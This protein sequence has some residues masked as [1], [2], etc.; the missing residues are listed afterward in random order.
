MSIWPTQ[1]QIGDGSCEALSVTFK[2]ENDTTLLQWC[3]ANGGVTEQIYPDP[4]GTTGLL[5]GNTISIT[6][7]STV[8]GLEGW[9][10]Q[11]LLHPVIT[12]IGP[13]GALV[14]EIHAGTVKRITLT[15]YNFIKDRTLCVFL[16]KD[17]NNN[18]PDR[19]QSD[20][21][22][23]IAFDAEAGTILCQIPTTDLAN[24]ANQ[25]SQV[26]AVNIYTPQPGEGAL[27][28]S[29]TFFADTG[30]FAQS[31]NSVDFRY[32]GCPKG[33]YTQDPLQS[34]TDC[35]RGKY[36]PVES[37]V[38]CTVCEQGKYQDSR[39]S[40]VC[41]NCPLGRFRS[42][43]EGSPA[44]ESIPTLDGP[45]ICDACQTGTYQSAG[46]K[47]IC[48]TCWDPA[49]A[50]L[51][52][53]YV[54]F[55]QTTKAT[56]Q[57]QC[58][59]SRNYFNSNR[60]S[61]LRPKCSECNLE[62][63][64]C[65]G[66]NGQPLPQQGWFAPEGS[67]NPNDFKQCS[68]GVSA[69]PGGKGQPSVEATVALDVTLDE[70]VTVQFQTTFRAEVSAELG[71][72]ETRVRILDV[73]PA[74]TEQLTQLQQQRRKKR[75]LHLADWRWLQTATSPAASMTA[76]NSTTNDIPVA[77]SVVIR[78][79]VVAT[80]EGQPQQLQNR[81]QS[82]QVLQ[83]IAIGM[84][85]SSSAMSFLNSTAAVPQRC[86]EGYTGFGCGKCADRWYKLHRK[87]EKC[88]DNS[89]WT[90]AVAVVS[91]VAFLG[92][93]AYFSSGRE[94]LSSVGVA[95][96][97]FFDAISIS[98][99]FLQIN[100]LFATFNIEWPSYLVDLF[101]W[102][103]FLSLNIELAR[104]E[105]SIR[106]DYFGRWSVI[107]LFLPFAAGT[108][109]FFAVVGKIWF[110][111]KERVLDKQI[112][113]ELALR[114]AAADTNTT[115]KKLM[116]DIVKDSKF[117]DSF[118]TLSTL[119]LDDTIDKT[120]TESHEVSSKMKQMYQRMEGEHLFSSKQ[121]LEQMALQKELAKLNSE[122]SE[123]RTNS[124]ADDDTLADA[125][126]LESSRSSSSSSL[127]IDENSSEANTGSSATS[128]D[129][130]R[131]PQTRRRSVS[132]EN[133]PGDA[134]VE[135]PTPDAVPVTPSPSKKKS[136]F[137]RA[138][139]KFSKKSISDD[140]SSN[141]AAN[142]GSQPSLRGRLAATKDGYEHIAFW[143]KGFS[144]YRFRLSLQNAMIMFASIAYVT[145]C[146]KVL[147]VFD[148]TG[149]EEGNALL[150]LDADPSVRCE[151][152]DPQYQ[153]LFPLAVLGLFVYVF[154]IPAGCGYL[155]Y[156]NR[157]VLGD[158][159]CFY[160]F[161]FLIDKY[162]R[163]YFYWELFVMFRKLGL[164]CATLYFTRRPFFQTAIGMV[165]IFIC[166]CSNLVARPYVDKSHD[167]LDIILLF[168]NFLVLVFGLAFLADGFPN[169]NVEEAAGYV[170]VGVIGVGMLAILIA[171][172]S[173]GRKALRRKRMTVAEVD[174]LEDLV[175]SFVLI[176]K[177]GGM[178][179][180]NFLYEV[181][182]EDDIPYV[183]HAMMQDLRE[184]TETDFLGALLR[185][186]ELYRMKE[187]DYITRAKYLRIY[188]KIAAK[189]QMLE[190][191]EAAMKAA[192]EENEPETNEEED[193]ADT[194][195]ALKSPVALARPGSKRFSVDTA[196]GVNSPEV[197][198]LQ[199]QLKQTEEELLEVQNIAH[200]ALE[201]SQDSE[202]PDIGT[203]MELDLGQTSYTASPVSV[204]TVDLVER[205]R[206]PS[207]TDTNQNQKGWFNWFKRSAKS[208]EKHTQNEPS[209]SDTTVDK[210]DAVSLT[211]TVRSHT[212]DSRSESQ[213][214]PS[215]N[216][217]TNSSD[218]D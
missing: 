142:F 104:P 76:G 69:C 180:H 57:Y 189:R 30:F 161:G 34:C 141:N 58:K 111:Y 196:G 203:G 191:K 1:M 153:Y 96:S 210:S 123:N 213:N 125:D 128:T 2:N 43:P 21:R 159:S 39:G 169:A 137:E 33:Q 124:I 24:T 108:F 12:N 9:S 32:R 29:G 199:K 18:I 110:A 50:S 195:D 177:H 77:S 14:S 154:G 70:A 53:A 184:T 174:D 41:V 117:A 75:R 44:Y 103:S 8:V 151:S 162:E 181:F 109:S 46:G 121:S 185:F 97:R 176:L 10:F 164:I 133:I 98:L 212:E 15:G 28:P 116:K 22:N 72:A 175:E 102:I 26:T 114:K 192:E 198:E 126:S 194:G 49:D 42:R 16:L 172:V 140:G 186:A 71:V 204:R 149:F 101:G 56:S 217:A 208:D 64:I 73:N 4:A 83:N 55:P 13:S 202:I 27:N 211:S 129:T 3:G 20:V 89:G 132:F 134:L 209:G 218:S 120:N 205:R 38:P 100:A 106:T 160:R 158:E 130:E 85:I 131:H 170:T 173:V 48:D 31:V 138:K 201:D 113:D 88:P 200:R 92:L 61:T 190:D 37:N 99:T 197:A 157:N 127:K 11:Y 115:D 152:D 19:T 79:E 193:D 107:M 74:T 23:P 59:C 80:D 122:K 62:A 91:L 84:N 187:L 168:I 146:T 147:E 36:S 35:P 183:L 81:L 155:L 93:L 156:R 136:V 51:R 165:V 112:N 7:V 63:A 206:R 215:N 207:K 105:C 90:I 216:N 139:T 143:K 94:A 54:T 6:Y 135:T 78:F 148:C 163:K 65:P 179:L 166:L 118:H 167:W 47:T 5:S 144:Y 171:A 60:D 214:P 86:G 45:L 178:T 40:T 68:G 150:R 87:C 25:N 67:T 17:V 119:S 188:H 145:V 66:F 52:S 95:M 182:A 82:V